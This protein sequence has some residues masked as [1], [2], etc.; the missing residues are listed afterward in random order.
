ML[1]YSQSLGAHTR[2]GIINSPHNK[3]NFLSKYDPPVVTILYL[4]L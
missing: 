3:A 4:L 1:E 2:G